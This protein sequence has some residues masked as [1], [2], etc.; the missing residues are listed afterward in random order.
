VE[1]KCGA[2]VH[3]RPPCPIYGRAAAKPTA[4]NDHPNTMTMQ[5][6]T[7]TLITACTLLATTVIAQI[8][9]VVVQGSGAPQVFSDFTEALEAAQPNDRLYLSGGVFPFEG[10][11]IIDK[12]VH[13]I[14]AGIHPDSTQVT[15]VTVLRATGT[16]APLIL[17]TAASGSTFTGIRFVH[18]ASNATVIVRYGTNTSDH[19]PTDII[20]QRCWFMENVNLASGNQN[21][22]SSAST[23]FDECIF[24]RQLNG[25][26]STAVVTRSIFDWTASQQYAVLWFNVGTLTMDNCVFLGALLSNSPG[27]IVR[28]SITTSSSY[29]CIGCS[30]GTFSNNLI[31]ATTV[32][33]SSLGATLSNNVT[34]LDPANM[35]V[36]LGNANTFNF[37][38][39]LRLPPGSP[40]IGA[41]T[42]GNDI[43]IYGS[44]SPYKDGA[45]PFNP[46]FRQADI[47]PSTNANGELPVNIRVAAQPN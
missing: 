36:S 26:G 47:A 12:P 25:F 34:G 7:L 1:G 17:T 43:G 33:T 39:D 30:N 27:A 31:T 2:I 35:F 19:S 37:N 14:G 45:I 20:F 4:W 38:D 3:M 18:Q 8:P 42:D 46:H 32:A 5:H 40:G 15:G 41:G 28:N 11:L 44:S 10:G 21:D 9:R 6:R 24:R 22:P 16:T 29:I 13:L 23:I